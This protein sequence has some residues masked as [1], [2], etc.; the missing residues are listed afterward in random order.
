MARR[1]EKGIDGIFSSGMLQTRQPAGPRTQ[2]IQIP[3]PT[4]ISGPTHPAPCQNPDVFSLSFELCSS[5]SIA[6]C[7]QNC[8]LA[9]DEFLVWLPVL[10]NACSHL[11][12]PVNLSSLCC[13]GR[14]ENEGAGCREGKGRKG[15]QTPPCNAPGAGQCVHC[16]GNCLCALLCSCPNAGMSG[17]SH[18]VSPNHMR[19]MAVCFSP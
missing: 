5:V 18:R 19:I 1:A 11:S 7:L 8:V 6:H 15:G 2:V 4:A 9:G 14:G 16:Q 10:P 17:G 12:L 13:A 3:A